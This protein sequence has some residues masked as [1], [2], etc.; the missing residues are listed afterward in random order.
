MKFKSRSQSFT[1]ATLL[2]ASLVLGACRPQKSGDTNSNQI[3]VNVQAS[4]D[5]ETIALGGEQL[6]TPYTFMLADRIFDLALN[7]DSTI[8]RLLPTKLC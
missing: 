8:K 3:H 4:M 2:A 7:M 1:V 5:A 6:V